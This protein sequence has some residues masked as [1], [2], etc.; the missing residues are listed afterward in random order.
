MPLMYNF[1]H[2][3]T[4]QPQH[5]QHH[6]QQ[7]HSGSH[8]NNGI[9]HHSGYSSGVLSNSTPSFTPSSNQNGQAGTTRGGQ[10]QQISEHWAEQL[11]QHKEAV[12]IHQAMV[13]QGAPNHFARV[14][15]GENRGLNISSGTAEVSH[16]DADEEKDPARMAETLTVKRRQDWANLDLSGQGLRILAPPLFHFDFLGELYISSN[17]LTHLPAAIGQ[18]RHL[19]HL[20]ASHNQLTELPIE[21]GMCVKLEKLMLFD[22]QLRTLPFELGALF[23]LELLG[24]EG[25]ADFDAGLRQEIMDKGTVALM[26]HLRENAP[27]KSMEFTETSQI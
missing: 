21:L 13:E 8:G 16:A 20:D 7:E 26:T 18:L 11:T 19:R 15:A 3:S 4:H 25:N 2:Q 14:R 12:R 6:L 1:Q 22:N 23:K 24:I 27:G 10:A 9:G 5:T 17:K